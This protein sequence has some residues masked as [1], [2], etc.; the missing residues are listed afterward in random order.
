MNSLHWRQ[1]ADS[2]DELVA[3][4]ELGRTYHVTPVRDYLEPE[5]PRD[6]A[7]VLIDGTPDAVLVD[8]RAAQQY[9]EGVEQGRACLRLGSA[10]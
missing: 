2:P 6:G 3:L 9:A 1:S 10:S 5:H 7:L 8:M 4:G